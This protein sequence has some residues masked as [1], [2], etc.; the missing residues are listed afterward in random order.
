MLPSKNI[1]TSGE[2]VVHGERT[3]SVLMH[4]HTAL[5][6]HTQL[7]EEVICHSHY[8]S[9]NINPR[10][11]N[12]GDNPLFYLCLQPQFEIIAVLR[13]SIE[14]PDSILGL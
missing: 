7:V 1:F 13:P 12:V 5:F 11:T 6:K 4:A 9:L 2:L 10:L 8:Y 3:G 14:M